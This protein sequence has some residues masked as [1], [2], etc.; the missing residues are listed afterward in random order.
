LAWWPAGV[1]FQP[2]KSVRGDEVRMEAEPVGTVV[3]CFAGGMGVNEERAVVHALRNIAMQMRKKDRLMQ[4]D[5]V[6]SGWPGLWGTTGCIRIFRR[7]VR[8]RSGV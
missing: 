4:G 3:G 5:S 7:V 6:S 8:L 2:L 1:S